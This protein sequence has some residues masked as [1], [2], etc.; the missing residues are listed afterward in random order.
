MIQKYLQK[1]KYLYAQLY[2]AS[3]KCTGYTFLRKYFF[4]MNN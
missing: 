3:Y 1:I 4:D 2:Y